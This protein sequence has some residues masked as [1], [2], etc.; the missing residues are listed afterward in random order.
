[1][2]HTLTIFWRASNDA[3]HQRFT[4]QTI[5]YRPVCT[6]SGTH[7][8]N[9]CCSTFGSHSNDQH[10]RTYDFVSFSAKL[11]GNHNHTA[12]TTSGSH[13]DSIILCVPAGDH[14]SMIPSDDMCHQWFILQI[15]SDRPLCTTSSSHFYNS[16]TNVYRGGLQLEDPIVGVYHYRVTIWD[17]LWNGSLRFH[18]HTNRTTDGHTKTFHYFECIVSDL[19][20][21]DS[22]GWHV[23]PLVRTINDILSTIVYH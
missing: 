21:D 15:M 8:Y 5:F 19:R 10:I 9:P 22:P 7:I 4:Q 14:T 3:Y 1:M 23:P 17:E 20:S 6:T 11:S 12:Y 2:V 16:T 18:C 13:R